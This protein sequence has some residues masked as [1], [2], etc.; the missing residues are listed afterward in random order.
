MQVLMKRRGG[1]LEAGFERTLC[2]E[3]RAIG[4]HTNVA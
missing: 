4:R 2:V 3:Q 1:C